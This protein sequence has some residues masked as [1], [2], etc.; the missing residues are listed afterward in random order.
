MWQILT[1]IFAVLG[2]ISVLSCTAFC[3]YLHYSSQY[4]DEPCED[5]INEYVN[6]ILNDMWDRN[7]KTSSA[8][9]HQLSYLRSV[10]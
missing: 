1:N 10:L 7:S 9:P 4:L 5:E 8:N 2:A 3:I 6:S